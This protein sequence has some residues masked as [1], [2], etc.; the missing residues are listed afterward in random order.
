MIPCRMNAAD[1]YEL[2]ILQMGVWNGLGHYEGDRYVGEDVP[3]EAKDRLKRGQEGTFEA[4]SVWDRSAK[5]IYRVVK[6][7]DQP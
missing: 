5:V 7:Q 3:Q 2:Q 1:V 4:E 6:K